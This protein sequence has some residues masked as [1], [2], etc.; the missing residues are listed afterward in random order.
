MTDIEDNVE[1]EDECQTNLE[2]DN[3]ESNGG[4]PK[5]KVV[6]SYCPIERVK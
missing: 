5:D 4:E 3:Y 6:L 1:F 2:K